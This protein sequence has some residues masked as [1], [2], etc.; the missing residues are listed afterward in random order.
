M[1]KKRKK[2]KKVTSASDGGNDNA[3]VVPTG[4]AASAASDSQPASQ[5]VAESSSAAQPVAEQRGGSNPVGSPAAGSRRRRPDAAALS[6]SSD[7]RATADAQ[8]DTVTDADG[9]SS[10]AAV[11]TGGTR[12][13]AEQDSLLPN[14]GATGEVVSPLPSGANATKLCNGRASSANDPSDAFARRGV[15]T[16]RSEPCVSSESREGIA[17]GSAGNS[18]SELSAARPPAH[19]TAEPEARFERAKRDTAAQLTDVSPPGGPHALPRT[20]A[21]SAAPVSASEGAATG[22][23]PASSEDGETHVTVDARRAAS[24]RGHAR[25]LSRVSIAST[26]SSGISEQPFAG[27]VADAAQ[28]AADAARVYLAA[29]AAEASQAVGSTHLFGEILG[30]CRHEGVA[31]HQHRAAVHGLW[32]RTSPLGRS[33]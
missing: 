7:L 23:R 15:E 3:S 29:V 14:A 17:S 13:A 25:S 18:R 30:A 28:E 9:A 12:P 11:G 19:A 24:R 33:V 1:P 32:W 27:A 22:P 26:V 20:S 8:H 4:V 6:E 21:A 31:I 2:A 16:V 10:G 5:E